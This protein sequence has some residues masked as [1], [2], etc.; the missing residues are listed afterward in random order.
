[1]LPIMAEALSWVGHRQTRARG[2]L[3][4]SLCHLDPAAELPLVAALYDAELEVA[5]ASGVRRVTFADWPSGYMAP[6][7]EANELLI[8]VRF[9][10]WPSSSGW[11]FREHTRRHGD[12]AI[13]AAGTIVEAHDGA[14][15]RCAVALGGA[16]ATV[17]RLHGLE[18]LL[19]GQPIAAPLTRLVPDAVAAF[20][21]V[22]DAYYSAEYRRRLAGTLLSQALGDALSRASRHG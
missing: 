3:G 4:G 18:E 22:G 1:M 9:R 7:L 21:F 12:F 2:T 15:A 19:I 17:A 13:I 6:S 8:G 5:S 10:R 11:G 16:A 20:P 14:I